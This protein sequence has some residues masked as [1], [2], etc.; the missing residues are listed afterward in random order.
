MHP[1]KHEATRYAGLKLRLIQEFGGEDDQAIRDTLQGMSDLEEMLAHCARE[2]ETDEMFI[3]GCNARISEI[4]DRIER[5]RKRVD[6]KRRLIS[7]CMS[8]AG[9]Q[10]ISQ[11][12]FTLS[13][14]RRKPGVVITDPDQLPSEYQRIK[15]EPNKTKIGDALRAGT[16][17]PGAMLGNS[18]LSLT[19]RRK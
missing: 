17:V 9:M 11:P 19:I 6:T 14:A 8:E 5:L 18:S 3:A 2:M 13:M 15:V 16:D 1:A 12:D 7:E 4:K 10:K